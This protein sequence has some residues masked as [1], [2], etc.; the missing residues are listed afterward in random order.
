MHNITHFSAC[1]F[2]LDALPTVARRFGNSVFLHIRRLGNNEQVEDG[3]KVGEN[4]E[5]ASSMFGVPGHQDSSAALQISGSKSSEIEVH[6]DIPAT[7]NADPLYTMAQ[8]IINDTVQYS[9][10]FGHIGH[11]VKV[12]FG[13]IVYAISWALFYWRLE[14]TGGSTSGLWRKANIKRN[15]LLIAKNLLE[16]D[17]IDAANDPSKKFK[18][19]KR[20]EISIKVNANQMCTLLECGQQQKIVKAK[21]IC[22]TAEVEIYMIKPDNEGHG[23][24][25][26]VSVPRRF[27]LLPG[28][29]NGMLL[30]DSNMAHIQD[31]CSLLDNMIIILNCMEGEKKNTY[32]LDLRRR[33]AAVAHQPSAVEICNSVEY[34]SK[35]RDYY[36][37]QTGISTIIEPIVPRAVGKREVMNEGACGVVIPQ[38][39]GG[40]KKPYAGMVLKK[41]ENKSFRA[42]KVNPYKLSAY[43]MEVYRKLYL[44]RLNNVIAVPIINGFN[45]SKCVFIE[46][47]GRNLIDS[48]DLRKRKFGFTLMVSYLSHIVGLQS[49]DNKSDNCADG[50]YDLLFDGISEQR[51]GRILG[52]SGEYAGWFKCLFFCVIIN[53]HT[54]DE[55][56]RGKRFWAAIYADASYEFAKMTYGDF[57][58][59]LKKIGIDDLG[60]KRLQSV[61]GL[62]RSYLLNDDSIQDMLKN[63]GYYNRVKSAGTE[64][65]DFQCSLFMLIQNQLANVELLPP[66]EDKDKLAKFALHWFF[67]CNPKE[68]AQFYNDIYGPDTKFARYQDSINNASQTLKREYKL[69]GDNA[70][71][72]ELAVDAARQ[73]LDSGLTSLVQSV[74][75]ML[76]PPVSSSDLGALS[77]TS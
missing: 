52:N 55:H 76:Q 60:I 47:G 57:I 45:K 58:V 72:S 68:I 46:G 51:K 67:A 29:K 22:N 49:L 35:C 14:K 19:I 10:D 26:L 71:A 21:R 56:R 17:L 7:K 3:N 16:F 34:R 30:Y 12:A 23:R 41:I 70:T 42:Y 38:F 13:I 1:F 33:I 37:V 4:K 8:E 50:R 36:D 27:S 48:P 32:N 77:I 15:L 24:L 62:V 64:L 6:N 61:A 2:V 63:V 39:P 75:D 5:S 73:E 44:L 53:G 20:E 59:K 66:F 9:S 11:N 31:F 18:K 28:V 65:N 40:V 69:N 74:K 25:Q 43:F 54:I